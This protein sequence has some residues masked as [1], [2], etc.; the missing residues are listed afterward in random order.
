MSIGGENT[1]EVGD[2]LEELADGVLLLLYDRSS[3]WLSLV[4]EDEQGS[5]VNVVELVSLTRDGVGDLNRETSPDRLANV[6]REALEI[7]PV[8]LVLG[9]TIP[10]EE[11][12]GVGNEAT[13]VSPEIVAR[14]VVETLGPL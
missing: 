14:H 12:G 4:C 11:I 2:S 5:L 10:S 9:E 13:E 7:E 6:E 8:A 3:S 1:G